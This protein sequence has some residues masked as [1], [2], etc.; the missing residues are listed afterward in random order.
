M[1]PAP[2]LPAGSSQGDG[3]QDS[4]ASA[5]TPTVVNYTALFDVDN[6]DGVLRPQ[7]TAQVSFV[8]RSAPGV[9]AVP[10]AALERKPDA[11]PGTYRARLR[12]ADGSALQRT[13]RIGVTDLV[14]GE[15]L[16]GLDEGDEVLLNVATEASPDASGIVIDPGPGMV[17]PG[18]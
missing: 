6:A 9:L 14:L 16:E 1:L 4:S 12:L 8:A 5:T 10:M 3:G 7:M 17:M 13:V 2:D 11:P 15:V 18:V